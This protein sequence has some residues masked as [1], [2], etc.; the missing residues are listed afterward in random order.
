M[1]YLIC[2]DISETKVRTRIAKILQYFG[3]DR[4]QY[5]V[6]GG[7]IKEN[8]LKLLVKKLKK[9]R[10]EEGKDSIIILPLRNKYIEL[11]SESMKRMYKDE[12]III[13]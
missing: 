1:R 10:V 6:F 12:K 4:L 13:F 8:H 3:L 5:S 9:M 2:Y 11:F 7:E